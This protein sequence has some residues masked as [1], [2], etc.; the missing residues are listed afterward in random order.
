M[1]NSNADSKHRFNTIC[2]RTNNWN[3]RMQLHITVEV[4][5]LSIFSIGACQR[6]SPVSARNLIA[7]LLNK[8]GAYVS[9]TNARIMSQSTPAQ[10]TST[11][12]L[13]LQFAN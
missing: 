8:T 2:S 1:P 7:F 4:T 13:H 5:D 3:G 9:G 11:Q 12:K 6:S 10:I